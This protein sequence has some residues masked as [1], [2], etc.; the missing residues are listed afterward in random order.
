MVEPPHAHAV[1]QLGKLVVELSGRQRAL[2]GQ[3]P[4]IAGV[5]DAAAVL[6]A[7]F[8]GELLQDI[9][10]SGGGFLIVGRQLE[11][12]IAVVRH[13]GGHG[14]NTAHLRAQGQQ[15]CQGAAQFVIVVNAAAEHK[16]TVQLDSARRQLGQVF[17]HLTPALVR[18]HPHPQFWVCRVD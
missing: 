4:L 5:D 1:L 11:Q 14:G 9:Q 8:L 12:L 17:Q 2:R 16:L 7:A 13:A 15:I 6:S 18:Q 3:V 10:C